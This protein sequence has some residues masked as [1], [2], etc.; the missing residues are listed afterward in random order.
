MKKSEKKD[1][2]KHI[3]KDDMEFRKQIKDTK[4]QIKDDI[5]LKKK[6]AKSR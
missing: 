2:L 3:K 6:I 5:K 1:L 4:G